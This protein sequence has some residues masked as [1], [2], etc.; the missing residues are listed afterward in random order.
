MGINDEICVPNELKVSVIMVL[1]GY[2]M[3]LW[4]YF[5]TWLDQEYTPII[6]IHMYWRLQLIMKKD[7]ELDI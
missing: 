5:N 1:K 2:S 6:V 7:R 3:S 4:D